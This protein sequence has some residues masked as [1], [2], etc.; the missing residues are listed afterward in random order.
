M[1]EILYSKSFGLTEKRN[2]FIQNKNNRNG[3]ET[4]HM[5]L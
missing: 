1:I 4:I 2:I 3:G 5:I